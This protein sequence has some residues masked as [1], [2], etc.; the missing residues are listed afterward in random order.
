MAGLKY[1]IYLIWPFYIM[2]KEILETL[3]T[4]IIILIALPLVAIGY[5]VSKL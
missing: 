3:G 4:V 5:L 1:N 2:I